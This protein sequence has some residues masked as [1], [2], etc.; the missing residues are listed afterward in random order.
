M[1]MNMPGAAR[2][3]AGARPTPGSIAGFVK[4]CLGKVAP[5][6]AR[7]CRVSCCRVSRSC[8]TYAALFITLCLCTLEAELELVVQLVDVSVPVPLRV[9]HEAPSKLRFRGPSRFSSMEA[10]GGETAPL[11]CRALS[12]RTVE[13]LR[14]QHPGLRPHAHVPPAEVRLQAV[15]VAR[16]RGPRVPFRVSESGERYRWSVIGC[17]AIL[18]KSSR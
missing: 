16:L 11:E 3:G 14:L 4:P 13:M 10:F 9:A 12:G 18:N 6:A 2:C 1:Q 7:C 15:A 17:S 5:T 8:V